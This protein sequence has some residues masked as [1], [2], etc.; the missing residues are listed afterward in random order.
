MKPVSEL[1]GRTL[2]L[3]DL[4][5]ILTILLE[6]TLSTLSF[7]S[8]LNPIGTVIRLPRPSR[9]ATFGTTAVL[10][11]DYV[12]KYE[13]RTLWG[14]GNELSRKFGATLVKMRARPPG[15]SFIHFSVSMSPTT[16]PT[17]IR[18]ML[19]ASDIGRVARLR[20][21]PQVSASWSPPRCTSSSQPAGSGTPPPRSK[22]RASI[23]T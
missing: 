4:L 22:V 2:T 21:T 12:N 20:S 15:A 5:D 14:Q 13:N 17:R 16:H 23:S 3:L 9:F 11:M 19:L 8:L 10:S 18:R 7:G 1:T 6:S